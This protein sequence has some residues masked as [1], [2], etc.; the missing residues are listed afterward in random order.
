MPLKVLAHKCYS[1][2]PLANTSHMAKPS[3]S[4]VRKY[5]LAILKRDPAKS[6]GKEGGYTTT[7]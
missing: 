4:G 6:H 3:I 5:I 2:I 7:L 1:D